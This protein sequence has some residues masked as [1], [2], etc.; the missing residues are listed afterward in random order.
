MARPIA[1]P[2]LMRTIALSV[3]RLA[4]SG[5][6][7]A[8]TIRAVAASAGVSTG[9][10]SHHFTNKRGL[11][12]FAIEYAY[13]PPSDWDDHTTDTATA[14]RRLLRRY[15]LTRREVRDWWRFWSAMTAHAPRDEDVAKWQRT[16]H[17]KLVEFF[18][19]VLETGAVREPELEAERLVALA[20]GLALRQ[21]VDDRR[22]VLATARALLEAE[23]ER[24]CASRTGVRLSRN[25]R[26]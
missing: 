18:A 8:M 11:V 6:F 15:L 22:A 3:F 13:A 25:A 7:D 23:I 24:L 5:G 4:A 21:L 2:E 20:H 10:L 17:R 14:L 19:S 26:A 16:T 12:K 9:T 1:D